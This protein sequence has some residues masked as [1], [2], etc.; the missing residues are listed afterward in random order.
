MRL[1]LLFVAVTLLSACGADSGGEDTASA[2]GGLGQAECELL[3]TRYQEYATSVAPEGKSAEMAGFAA[4]AKGPLVEECLAGE[5][6]DAEAYRCVAD[7]AAGSPAS[8]ACIEQALGR[9]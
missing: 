8:H 7:A 1:P 4:A 5:M 3:A 2:T 6:F 9:S